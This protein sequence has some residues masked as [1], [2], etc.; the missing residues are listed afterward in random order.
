V[1]ARRTAPARGRCRVG[2]LACARST[3]TPL[4][5]S[6]AVATTFSP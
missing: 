2:V 6:A 1:G 4:T 5:K 3:A